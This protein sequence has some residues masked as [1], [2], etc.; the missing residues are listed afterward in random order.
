MAYRRMHEQRET[1]HLLVAT[2]SQAAAPASTAPSAKATTTAA[3]AKKE[4]MRRNSSQEQRGHDEREGAE[5]LD[6]DVQRRAGRVFER[7]ADCIPDDGGF[8]RV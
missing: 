3:T 5:Q 2:D 6:Q 4:Y 7:I 8:V 1:T